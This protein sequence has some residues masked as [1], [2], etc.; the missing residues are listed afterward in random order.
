MRLAAILFLFSII[1]GTTS[2]RIRAADA[3]FEVPAGQRQLFLDDYGIAKL[4]G[5]HRSLHSP[6]K[7]GAVIRGP[8]PTKTIQIRS[9]P[10]WDPTEMLY[11]LWAITVDENLWQ[12]RDGLHWAPGPQTN[13]RISMAVHDPSEVDPARAKAAA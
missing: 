2:V 1:V 8:D 6:I 9:A 11:K 13:L 10:A 7:R 5:L 4:E 3:V 12:S